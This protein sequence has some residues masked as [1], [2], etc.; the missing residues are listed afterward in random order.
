MSWV[1]GRGWIINATCINI[2]DLRGV[3]LQAFII[4]L[5]GAILTLISTTM[6][7]M[8]YWQPVCRC[9]KRMNRISPEDFGEALNEYIEMQRRIQTQTE[10]QAV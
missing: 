1:P 2:D 7:C 8:V 4:Q 10:T 5:I 6:I 3:T 9:C